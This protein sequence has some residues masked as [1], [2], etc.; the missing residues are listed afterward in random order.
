MACE[1]FWRDIFGDK[2]QFE[3]YLTECCAEKI[4]KSELAW[5]FWQLYKANDF[6]PISYDNQGPVQEK[7]DNNLV[8]EVKK[9]DRMR[10]V[11]EEILK[12]P[13]DMISLSADEKTEY[14]QSLVRCKKELEDIKLY[15][16]LNDKLNRLIDEK[17][18]KYQ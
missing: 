5:N 12:V 10:R 6:K 3:S 9:L 1:P 11:E 18:E 8:D 17:L 7:I 4:E 16:S 13:D 15:I 14:K 2:T